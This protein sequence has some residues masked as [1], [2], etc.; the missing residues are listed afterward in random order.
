VKTELPLHAAIFNLPCVTAIVAASL[1]VLPVFRSGSWGDPQL[2]SL[3]EQ[4]KRNAG[5]HITN[6]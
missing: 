2:M 5:D 1:P 3:L 4:Q 6:L